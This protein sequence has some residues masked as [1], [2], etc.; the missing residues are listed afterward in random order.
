MFLST[1]SFF[2]NEAWFL[3]EGRTFLLHFLFYFQTSQRVQRL[4]KISKGDIYIDLLFR[5]LVRLLLRVF[6]IH[7]NHIAWNYSERVC[8]NVVLKVFQIYREV[9]A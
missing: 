6:V 2:V 1:S 7:N 9:S 8:F 3:I 5:R 4:L